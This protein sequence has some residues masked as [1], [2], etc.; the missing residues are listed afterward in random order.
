L[1]EQLFAEVPRMALLWE[2]REIVFLARGD[3]PWTLAYGSG[4]YGPPESSLSVGDGT[5]TFPAALGRRSYAAPAA[6][7]KPG[8]ERWRQ[9]VLWG[10]LG[11]AAA[12]L[13]G[14]AVYIVKS[15]KS[16]GTGG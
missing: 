15:A 5:E 10:I 7:E 12:V 8:T 4:V 11:F 6:G 16:G 2:A 1:G 3:G 13:C 9:I 14:L